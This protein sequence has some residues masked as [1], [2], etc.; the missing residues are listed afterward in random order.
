MHNVLVVSCV[1]RDLWAATVDRIKKLH[2]GPYFEI[3]DI[4][5]LKQSFDFK[6]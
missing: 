4:F 6:S 1:K 2:F 5:S 3:L